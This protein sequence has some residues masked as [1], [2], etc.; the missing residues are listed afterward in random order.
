MFFK[1]S[2]FCFQNT[3]EHGS[4]VVIF[5]NWVDFFPLIILELFGSWLKAL[6]HHL[7]KKDQKEKNPG[8]FPLKGLEN[9]PIIKSFSRHGLHATYH[10]QKSRIK[11]CFGGRQS[12]KSRRNYFEFWQD[13]KVTRQETKD[14]YLSKRRQTLFKS[15]SELDQ[16]KIKGIFEF[17]I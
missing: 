9:S 16:G 6:F 17:K 15:S 7:K 13:S 4:R 14:F 3:L 8:T 1:F 5:K 2:Y 10:L 12:K 11:L